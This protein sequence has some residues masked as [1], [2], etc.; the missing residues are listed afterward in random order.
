[1]TAF[2]EPWR[3]S[4]SQAVAAWKGRGFSSQEITLMIEGWLTA[5]HGIPF[6]EAPVS[7]EVDLELP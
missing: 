5:R 4:L 7:Q 1:M 3:E 2:S 6:P